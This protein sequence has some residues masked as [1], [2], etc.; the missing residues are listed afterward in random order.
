[1]HRV[2]PP[3]GK[4]ASVAKYSVVYFSRP[5]DEVLLRRLEGGDVIPELGEGEGEEEVV[6]SKDWILRRA[7]GRRVDGNVS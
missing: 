1:M 5:E 7:M 2:M 4:Q 3:P 6:R